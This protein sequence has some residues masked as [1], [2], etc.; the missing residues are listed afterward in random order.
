MVRPLRIEFPS[1]VHQVTSRGDRLEPILVD[2]AYRRALLVVL[3]PSIIARFGRYPL[4]LFQT[5]AI[6]GRLSM[7]EELAFLTEPGSG[8]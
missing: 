7:P 2:D 8:F 6:V 3:A 5:C 1:A 4:P